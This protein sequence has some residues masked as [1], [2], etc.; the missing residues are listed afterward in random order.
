MGHGL[1][2]HQLVERLGINRRAQ[3]LLARGVALAM[4]LPQLIGVVDGSFR[5]EIAEVGALLFDGVVGQVH[6]HAHEHP[7]HQL[8]VVERLGPRLAAEEEDLA[9]VVELHGVVQVR[10]ERERLDGGDRDLLLQALPRAHYDLG[11][12]WLQE[13]ETDVVVVRSAGEDVR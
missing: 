2:R 4:E 1:E 3:E 11:P 7:A 6:S 13:Y 5:Q 8:G 10:D 12:A 9:V